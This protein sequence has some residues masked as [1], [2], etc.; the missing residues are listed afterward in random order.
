M[1]IEGI[2]TAMVTP[3]NDDGTLSEERTRHLIEK[4]LSQGISGLFI[5]GTNGEFFALTD[6]EK[7][8][9]AKMV[10]TIVAKRI[11]VYVGTGGIATDQVITLS[12]KMER[13]GVSGV[14]VITPYLVSLRQEELY[15]HYERIASKV[16]LPILLYNIPQNTKNNIEAETL[17]KLSQIPN[18]VG[19]KDS[20]GDLSQLQSYIELTSQNDFSILVGSDSKILSGLQMG[21]SG[22]VAATSNVLTKTDIG[23]YQQ[24]KKGHQTEASRL[25]KSI[26][27]Y[28]NVL[29]YGTVPAVLKYSLGKIG[30]PVGKPRSPVLSRL[31]KEEKQAIISVLNDYSEAENFQ[32]N[33][34]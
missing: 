16:D 11:P 8:A 20:S 27:A 4:L 21:A 22:A 15:T 29:K 25:Q 31:T 10:V 9:Y 7:V 6:D 32:E 34:T 18:I 13:L 23:I 12:Q 28:R 5:L 2:I 24:F 14:S 19:V 30:Y 17:A 26:D 33:L 3:L 1:A